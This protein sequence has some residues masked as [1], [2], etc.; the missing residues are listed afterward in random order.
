MSRNSVVTDNGVVVIGAGASGLA[1]ADALRRRNIEVRII[2]R[3]NRAGEAWYHRHPQLRLNTHRWLSALPGLAIPRT[4]GT[5]ASR[6]GI[7]RYLGDYAQRLDAPI[8]Y[9]VEVTR[10]DRAGAGWVV[11]T[12]AGDYHARH[13]VVATG[14]DRVPVMPAW[15]GRETFAGG[16]LHAADF[17][18]LD[19]YRKRRILVVGAGNSGTDILNHLAKIETEQVW[20]SVRHGP[21]IFPQRLCG[22]PMQLLSP[23]FA[24]MPARMADAMLALTERIAF[25]RLAKWGLRKHRQG[26]ITRLLDNGTAPAIDNGFI[27][28]L[29]AG[30]VTVVPE[31]ECFDTAGVRLTDGR[32]IEPDVVIAATGYRTGLESLLGHIDVLDA[33]GVPRIH[34]NGQ[35]DAYPGLWFTGMQPRLTGFFQL[36]R[37]NARKIA[38]AIERKLDLH[39]ADSPADAVAV[40]PDSPALAARSGHP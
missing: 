34:G 8:D 30:R 7:I 24:V 26:G 35:M 18:T 5:F 22:I 23:L 29:K 3:A 25:G 27:A 4:E 9:G 2:E 14:Y 28:A 39:A 21:V 33:A 38:R 6:D 16:L 40:P 32:Y 15:K 17:G 37:G 11:T 13:V 10:I 19:S 31:I 20:V 12:S 36:A 1:A